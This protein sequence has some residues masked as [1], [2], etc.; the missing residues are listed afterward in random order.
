MFT[1]FIQVAKLL[2]YSAVGYLLCRFRILNNEHSGILSKLLVWVFLPCNI[3]KTFAKNCTVSYIS[4]NYFLVITSA[5][6]VSVLGIT[7]HF[8]SKLMSKD[9]YKRRVY[10][11][12]LVISNNGYMGYPMAEALLGAQG[13]TNAM[14]FSLPISLYIYTYGYCALSKKS[15]SLKKLINPVIITML[16]GIVT[17][18]C[19]LPIPDFI[20]SIMN[21]LSA[22]MAPVSM[23]LAGI[24]ISEF[25]FK[26][27][28]SDPAPYITS[29]LRLILIPLSIG[30]ILLLVGAPKEVLTVAVL[31]FSMPCG[32][33]TIVF[34]KSIDEDCRPGAG[35]A[36]ISSLF[37]CITVPIILS[38]FGIA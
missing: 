38:I 34:P 32:L 22:C 35:I 25:S 1:V 20:Y 9:P 4:E 3:F 12:S 16:L 24:V 18:L 33:N 29:V 7:M 27:L 30:G 8:V 37:S 15:F 23:L 11:Y 26:N 2:I 19:A 14:I 5:V 31:L 6:I 28:L 36:L 13:L 21:D 10:E 17:G